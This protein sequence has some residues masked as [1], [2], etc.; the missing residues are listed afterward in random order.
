M[1]QKKRQDAG[2]TIIELALVIAIIGILVVVT[3]PK[4]SGVMEQYRLESS[5]RKVLGYA[6]YARQ[7][8]IDHRGNHGINQDPG[9]YCV[10]I[11]NQQA[12]VFFIPDDSLKSIRVIGSTTLDTGVISLNNGVPLGSNSTNADIC[13]IDGILTR[14]ISYNYR[15]F[16]Q[17]PV[18]NQTYGLL[19]LKAA[20]GE[21]VG[22]YFTHTFGNASLIWP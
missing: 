7:L 3:A 10:G 21:T 6:D 16:V 22:V 8:A 9:R 4:Y 11:N 14:Y 17:L 13:Q 12:V 19:G 1:G 18:A 2:F 5:A 20:G 15:G